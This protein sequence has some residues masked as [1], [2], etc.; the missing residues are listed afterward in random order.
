VPGGTGYDSIVHAVGV[1]VEVVVGRGASVVVGTNVVVV[2]SGAFVTGTVELAAAT[3]VVGDASPS[4]APSAT[5][6]KRRSARRRA[7]RVPIVEGYVGD[8]QPGSLASGN[9]TASDR[10]ML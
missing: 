6:A 5:A 7:G 9:I 2:G 4:H 1:A 8:L 3:S 10:M